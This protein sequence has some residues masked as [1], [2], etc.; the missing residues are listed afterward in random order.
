MKKHC[1]PK[2]YR[3]AFSYLN[4]IANLSEF[5]TGSAYSSHKFYYLF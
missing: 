4:F 1:S 3:R 5:P 2:M